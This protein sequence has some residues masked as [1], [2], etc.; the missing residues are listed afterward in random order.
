MK[1][2]TVM[3]LVLALCSISAFAGTQQPTEG[4]TGGGDNTP[5]T[6]SMGFSATWNQ[7]IMQCLLQ[8][9]SKPNSLT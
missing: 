5:T 4:S 2:L 7:H 9:I 3:V 6:L 8:K 1:R